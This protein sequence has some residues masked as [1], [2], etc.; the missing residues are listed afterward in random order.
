MPF[1]FIRSDDKLVKEPEQQATLRAIR[2]M[3]TEGL[4]LNEIARR[5]NSAKARPAMG[6]KWYASSVKSVS[7]TLETLRAEG[8]LGR[9]R[10]SGVA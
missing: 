1:A 9:R 5:L 4:S 6:R 8:M 3:Q 10:E 7:E 2:S